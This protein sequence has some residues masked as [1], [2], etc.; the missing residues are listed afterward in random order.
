MSS[1]LEKG[2]AGEE[3]PQ[4]EG[5]HGNNSFISFYARVSS[6]NIFSCVFTVML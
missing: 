6:F 4:L 3:S 5:V 1:L 2:F